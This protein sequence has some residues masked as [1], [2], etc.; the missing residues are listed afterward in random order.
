MA[1]KISVIMPVYNS[2]PYLRRA[3][4]SVCNQT[5]KDIEILCIDDGSTDGSAILLAHYAALDRRIRVISHGVNKGYAFA[6]NSG[7]DA[8]QGETIGIV[9][10]D[11][12][13]GK[14]FFSELWKVYA[15]GECDIV[16]GRRKERSIDGTWHE[17][18]LNRL[19][20]ED[21]LNFTWQWTTAIYRTAF[22]QKYGIKLSTEFSSGQ[23]TLFLHQLMGHEPHIN[24][25]DN[26]IYYYLHNDASMTKSQ[27]DEFYLATRM[28]IARLLKNY[29]PKYPLAR[30]RRNV[31][32]AIVKFLSSAVTG[33]FSGCD[34]A[35]Y[36]PV[37]KNLLSDD[38]FYAPQKE[39]PLLAQAH[40]AK[41]I[42]ELKKTLIMAAT[43][44]NAKSLR[45][46]LRRKQS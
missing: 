15:A 29:I 3:L 11:D 16:K 14:N 17:T 42:Q 21:P 39:F 45:E 18:D 23:D 6:M 1:V 25:S 8:V 46:R 2:A 33:Q 28:V 41:N 4:A 12:V 37:I 30:Q 40:E 13:I 7:F 27:P 20:K 10:S 22:I 35:P 44:L 34:L 36:F 38:E 24:F 5:F 31:F 32:A 26:A 19:I 43:S 9:D